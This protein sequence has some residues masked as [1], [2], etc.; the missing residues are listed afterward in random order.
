MVFH[1]LATLTA[2]FGESLVEANHFRI[3]IND[4]YFTDETYHSLEKAY[5]PIKEMSKDEEIYHIDIEVRD[6]DGGTMDVQ[7]V[8]EDWEKE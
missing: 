2:I 1:S 8:Y 5:E 3:G 4:S 6:I 7:T